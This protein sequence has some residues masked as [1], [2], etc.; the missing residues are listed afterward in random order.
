MKIELRWYTT[1]PY[2]DKAVLQ[3]RTCEIIE[4]ST[5]KE[6]KLWSEWITVP[7]IFKEVLK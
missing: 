7:T 5:G 3:Y 4:L 1:N 2:A 6:T